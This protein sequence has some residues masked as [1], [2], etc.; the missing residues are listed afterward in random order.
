MMMNKVIEV[1]KEKNWW[2]LT[3]Q[4]IRTLFLDNYK[5]NKNTT[6][7]L[8]SRLNK[9]IWTVLKGRE[10][11]DFMLSMKLSLKWKLFR[12]RRKRNFLTIILELS[13]F[14]QEN[15]TS[16]TYLTCSQKTIRYFFLYSD[17]EISSN[18]SKRTCNGQ[19]RGE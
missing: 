4:L 17:K 5:S 7:I 19:S 12:K 9:L 8:V 15:L 1:E 10:D 11:K 2:Q 16:N 14:L 6:I 3:M 18:K 13:S